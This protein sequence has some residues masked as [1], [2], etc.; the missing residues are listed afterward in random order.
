MS[1]LVLSSVVRSAGRPVGTLTHSVAGHH[2][3]LTLLAALQNWS[4]QNWSLQN[5]PLQN[6]PLFVVHGQVIGRISGMVA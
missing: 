6:W 2:C 3:D 4:L 1:R 5:W